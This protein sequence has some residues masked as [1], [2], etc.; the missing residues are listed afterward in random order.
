MNISNTKNSR[1]L[2][3]ALKYFDGYRVYLGNHDVCIDGEKIT[4]YDV[5]S[6]EF[7]TNGFHSY[8]INYFNGEQRTKL[9]DAV[10][11]GISNKLEMEYNKAATAYYEFE[12]K[13][14]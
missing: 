8:K 2:H 13:F 9:V 11:E 1:R 6:S 3:A 5:Q 4:W 10:I 12:R 14:Q 7:Q